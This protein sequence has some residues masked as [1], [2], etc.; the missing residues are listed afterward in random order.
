M[1]LTPPLPHCGSDVILTS[2]DYLKLDE[3]KELSL[4]HCVIL[5]YDTIMRGIRMREILSEKE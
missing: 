4:E 5:V 1:R 2:D 3:G